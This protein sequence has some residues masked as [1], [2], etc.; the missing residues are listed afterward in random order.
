MFHYWGFN[1]L[2][3][4]AQWCRTALWAIRSRWN[5]AHGA[6]SSP[7]PGTPKSG[8]MFAVW[9]AAK[10]AENDTSFFSTSLSLSLAFSIKLTLYPSGQKLWKCKM[11]DHST[12][13]LPLFRLAPFVWLIPSCLSDCPLPPLAWVP[14]PPSPR[15][16]ML[17]IILPASTLVPKIRQMSCSTH[18]IDSPQ[19]AN[20]FQ[21]V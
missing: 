5:A 11:L 20:S 12:S 1:C 4:N 7:V 18:S 6:H 8:Q 14:A 15:W 17:L 16:A 19:I 21:K 9:R 13:V 10:P 2:P 3:F